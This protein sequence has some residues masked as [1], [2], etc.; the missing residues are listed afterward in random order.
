MFIL[1]ISQLQYCNYYHFL[2]IQCKIKFKWE[3]G[4]EQCYK[5]KLKGG[6]IKILI[7]LTEL[8]FVVCSIV[9]HI[10]GH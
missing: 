7:V 1:G 10:Q 8:L 9:D 4:L 6:D 5:G 3:V 2:F